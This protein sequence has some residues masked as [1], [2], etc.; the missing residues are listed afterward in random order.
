[1]KA[2][3]V[4]RPALDHAGGPPED[5][6]RLCAEPRPAA[7][8]LMGVRPTRGLLGHAQSVRATTAFRSVNGS[9]WLASSP[10]VEARNPPPHSWH[11]IQ[12]STFGSYETPGILDAR[13]RREV[14][15]ADQS[16]R[17]RPE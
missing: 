16:I 17:I 4:L 5:G 10:S 9:Q 15:I 12:M 2:A 11:R 6:H 3:G 7:G 14:L 1:L 8:G 13:K